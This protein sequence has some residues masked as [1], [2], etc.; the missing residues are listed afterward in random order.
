MPNIYVARRVKRKALYLPMS[1]NKADPSLIFLLH[2]TDRDELDELVRA[3]LQKQGVTNESAVQAIIDKAE[4]GSEMRIKVE[5]ARKELRKL[6]ALRGNGNKL[7][8]TGFRKWKPAF[9]RPIKGK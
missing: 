6:M 1:Q 9:Y 5:E 7:M 3:S 8:Q 2:K 4:A